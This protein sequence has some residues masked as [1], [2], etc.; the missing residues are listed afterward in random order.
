MITKDGYL[1]E[2]KDLKMKNLKVGMASK[3]RG[4]FIVIFFATL[5]CIL[6]S[7]NQYFPRNVRLFIVNQS[8]I[9]KV[10][11]VSTFLN[12]ERVNAAPIVLK[13]YLYQS[14]SWPTLSINRRH[15]LIELTIKL[16]GEKQEKYVCKLDTGDEI[17][18]GVIYVEYHDDG[19]KCG[20]FVT[21]DDFTKIGNF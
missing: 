19:V 1:S 9:S 5:S 10:E 14:N 6:W 21:Y 20:R 4:V 18:S 17:S 13:K 8:S 2:K 16:E 15:S 7:L 11:L 3:K 12:G